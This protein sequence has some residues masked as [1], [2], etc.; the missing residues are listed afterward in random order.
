MNLRQG[1]LV[2]REFIAEHFGTP[3]EYKQRVMEYIK[4]RI[5]PEDV[6]RYL[7]GLED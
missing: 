3:Q 7:R 2:N 6:S 5:M 1:T 4:T